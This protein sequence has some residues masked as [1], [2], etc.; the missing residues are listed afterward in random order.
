MCLAVHW[1][2]QSYGTTRPLRVQ[3]RNP[4]RWGCCD[5]S[6]VAGSVKRMG[7]IWENDKYLLRVYHRHMCFGTRMTQY[8]NVARSTSLLGTSAILFTSLTS[9]S[10][11][12]VGSDGARVQVAFWKMVHS[13]ENVVFVVDDRLDEAAVVT[14]F[15]NF[16][17]F[18]P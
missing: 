17:S 1:T 15:S 11:L 4:T 14:T 9:R 8:R 3:F 18:V 16:P 5:Y 7:L 2:S 12:S 6:L 10:R 13:S